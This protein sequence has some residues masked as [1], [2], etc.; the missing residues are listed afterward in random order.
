MVSLDRAHRLH[1][2]YRVCVGSGAALVF[3]MLALVSPP[4]TAQKQ[5]SVSTHKTARH[6]KARSVGKPADPAA[7]QEKQETPP[8]PP[9]PQWPV[10]SSPEPA[11]VT[12]DSHGL[13]INASN[14]SLIQI[15]HDYSVATG[16]KIEGV[17]NDQ[18]IF[19]SYGPGSARDVL[20]QLLAGSGYNVLMI[21][22]LGQGAPREIML[23]S[24][25]PD[26][27]Q[28]QMVRPVPEEED[29]TADSNVEDPQQP[30][31]PI[32]QPQVLRPNMPPGDQTPRTP[33]QIMEE[34]QKRQQQLQQQQQENQ[35]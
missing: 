18:R 5:A 2:I 15:L 7:I 20:T 10:N 13:H 28:R 14:S 17:S 12:W 1:C 26:T 9:A 24:R 25:S 21:G 29:N 3:A 11:H 19:G 31:S 33:Q 4:A 35:E 32:I 27:G 23:S 34:M 6:P 30:P 16:S 22:D 8:T